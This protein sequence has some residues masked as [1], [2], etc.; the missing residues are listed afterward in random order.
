ML[1]LNVLFSGDILVLCWQNF[2]P[3]TTGSDKYH[4]CPRDGKKLVKKQKKEGE[5]ESKEG[6]EIIAGRQTSP[7]RAIQEVLTD[8]K[9]KGNLFMKLKI[10]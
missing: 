8:Q 5:G 7:L 4:T 2:Y 1:F 3:A 9:K 10:W 6:E